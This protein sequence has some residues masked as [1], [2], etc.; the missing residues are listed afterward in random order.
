MRDANL[1]ITLLKEMSDD[2]N[3]MVLAPVNFGGEEQEYRRN[4]HLRL[5]VDCGFA[6]WESSKEDMARVT[7]KGYDFLNAIEKCPDARQLFLELLDGGTDYERAAA[8]A[9]QTAS[10]SMLADQGIDV[11]DGSR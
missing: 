7:N 3:G 5:L 10:D 1:M 2:V 11:N 9:V 8:K 4:H 6:G